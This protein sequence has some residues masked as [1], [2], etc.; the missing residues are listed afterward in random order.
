MESACWSPGAARPMTAT[1]AAQFSGSRGCALDDIESSAAMSDASRGHSEST[2]STDACTAIADRPAARESRDGL[3]G[4]RICEP[5]MNLAADLGVLVRCI[6]EHAVGVRRE[7]C[8]AE[9]SQRDLACVRARCF[10]ENARKTRVRCFGALF[11]ARLVRVPG[12]G[13]ERIEK[14][15]GELAFLVLGIETRPKKWIRL[16]LGFGDEGETLYVH[17]EIFVLGRLWRR[18]YRP[19]RLLSVMVP[20]GSEKVD[21]QRANREHIVVAKD[22]DSLSQSSGSCVS[23]PV[24]RHAHRR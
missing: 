7:A 11:V 14:G 10:L 24:A 20:R 15:I 6:P 23:S 19:Q 1:S 9:R 13:A 8:V 18:E 5:T 22:R 3:R 16:R 21:H 17:N 12:G 2:W 4:G